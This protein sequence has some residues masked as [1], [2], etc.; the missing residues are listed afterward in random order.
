MK[1]SKNG[2][3]YPTIE[4]ARCID[5]GMCLRICSFVVENS[6]NK[7]SI[8]AFSAYAKDDDVRQSCSSGGIAHLLCE[9]MARQGYNTFGAIYN[10][11]TDSVEHIIAKTEQERE[12]VKGSKYLQSDIGKNLWKI[13]D[14][15]RYVVIGTPCQIASIRNIAKF[16]RIEENLLL[17][18]FFCHGVPSHL[19]WSRFLKQMRTRYKTARFDNIAFRDKSKGW[20]SFV[21]RFD[22]QDQPSKYFA[23]NEGNMFYKL[24]L[25]NTCLATNCYNCKFHYLESQ[26]D[27]RI[28]DLWGT[29]YSSDQKG[30][31]G[32]LTFTEKGRA[33]LKQIHRDVVMTKET[34]DV[35]TQGQIKKSLIKPC[36]RGFVLWLL[37][38]QVALHIIYSIAILPFK[39]MK[40]I[41]R[42]MTG[43]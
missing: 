30:I 10:A 5:C 31:S 38:K 4:D 32:V 25:S 20:H 41:K 8:E 1:P 35:V 22:T 34:I 37:K 43:R 2:F 21:M 3:S 33:A 23:Q 27:L 11:N 6:N 9:I 26:A 29:K 19:L 15:Q 13:F 7:E 42:K 18:D 14:S 36:N 39:M 28:G 16:K 12:T 24:F 40:F 17:V